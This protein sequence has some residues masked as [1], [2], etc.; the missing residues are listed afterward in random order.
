MNV[1]IVTQP[2]CG[3]YGGILQNYALQTVLRSLGVTPITLDIQT[4]LNTSYWNYFK[5]I[6]AYLI[7]KY[8]FSKKV[9]LLPYN[10]V[11]SA[12]IDDF[13]R[14]NITVSETIHKYTADLIEKYELHCL[15]VGS[16]QVWRPRYNVYPLSMFLDF[17]QGYDIKKVAY[18]ASFGVDKWEFNNAL[19]DKCKSLIACFDSVSV[20]EVTG[21]TLCKEHWNI[22]A[23]KVLD[24]TILLDKSVYDEISKE[25]P[26]STEKYIAVYA[27]NI[28]EKAEEKIIEFANKK[29]LSIKFYTSDAGLTLSIPEW[30]ASIRDASFVITDSFHGT[31][32]SI[33]YNKD[34]YSIVN[35]G[36][37]AS[38]FESLL[39]EFEL[40]SRLLDCIKFEIP[41]EDNPIIWDKVNKKRNS[42]KNQ[43]MSFLYNALIVK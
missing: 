33:I 12:V 43:S 34:F 28:S 9:R 21:I 24:P 37:G 4:H 36:R 31:A 30:I 14:K 19:S 5:G 1:G 41:D 10:Q 42:L 26:R 27:L 15:I 32:F 17:A 3:N 11:R 18:A 6:V 40:T 38:R 8:L 16:D 23:V 2:L 13:V 39:S 25:V 7:N 29:C 35:N 20:R 22:D